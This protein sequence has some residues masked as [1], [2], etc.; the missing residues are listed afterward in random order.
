MVLFE[1]LLPYTVVAMIY[2]YVY[3]SV[4][5]HIL[6]YHGITIITIPWFQFQIHVDKPVWKHVLICVMNQICAGLSCSVWFAQS[7]GFM[8]EV[9]NLHNIYTPTLTNND[10]RKEKSQ[11]GQRHV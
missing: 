5:W 10:S 2:D 9:L 11:K 8:G 7:Q 3:H 1:M 6:K 4:L